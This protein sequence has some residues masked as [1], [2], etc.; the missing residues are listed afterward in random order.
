MLETDKVAVG[1]PPQALS[2]HTAQVRAER[3][4][5][6]MH[7]PVSRNDNER[8]QFRWNH[9]REGGREASASNGRSLCPKPHA[10][11]KKKEEKD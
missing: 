4:F 10:R 6:M 1:D 8:A 9:R 3:C 11:V 7:P 5:F 2:R